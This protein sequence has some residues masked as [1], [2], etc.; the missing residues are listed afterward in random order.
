MKKIYIIFSMFFFSV[1]GSV[2]GSDFA[3]YASIK[4]PDRASLFS[5]SLCCFSGLRKEDTV[6]L[7]NILDAL[8]VV[9]PEVLADLEGK[10]SDDAHSMLWKSSLLLEELGFLEDKVVVKPAWRESI[11]EAIQT[12]PAVVSLKDEVAVTRSLIDS[13]HRIIKALKIVDPDV[14]REL[15]CK[16]MSINY[17]MTPERAAKLKAFGFLND[18]GHVREFLLKPIFHMVA[19]DGAECVKL[20][21]RASAEDLIMRFAGWEGSVGINLRLICAGTASPDMYARVKHVYPLLLKSAGFMTAEEQEFIVKAYQEHKSRELSND[22]FTV[23]PVLSLENV[24]ARL[25]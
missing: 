5:T 18:D 1:F 13:V 20:V 2:V 6:L 22:L 10:C 19:N 16:C 9:E 21:R 7:V 11:L 25:S 15:L 8:K 12:V 17:V 4:M 24:L 14:L 3:G 23:V